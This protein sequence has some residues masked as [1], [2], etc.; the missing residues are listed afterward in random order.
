MAT[1]ITI[2]MLNN[3]EIFVFLG[4]NLKPTATDGV[5]DG[6]VVDDLGS[7]PSFSSA[8]EKVGVGRS[9]ERISN[10]LLII[11][12]LFF[13]IFVGHWSLS[14]SLSLSLS[15]S[16]H[17]HTHTQTRRNHIQRKTFV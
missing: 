16:T 14:L 7:N 4:T 12:F 13:I 1:L 6:S 11:I 10:H 15:Q 8:N 9:S 2:F 17:T 5:E 3:L